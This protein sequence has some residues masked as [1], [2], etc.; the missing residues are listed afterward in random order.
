MVVARVNKQFVEGAL[1]PAVRSVE[2]VIVALLTDATTRSTP[3]GAAEHVWPAASASRTTWL[4]TMLASAVPSV[5]V[6]A[7]AAPVWLIALKDAPVICAAAV[8]QLEQ[9]VVGDPVPVRELV[10]AQF[11]EI[12]SVN[13]KADSPPG[14]TLS[15]KMNETVY[16]VNWLSTISFPLFVLIAVMTTLGYALR[17]YVVE[18]LVVPPPARPETQLWSLVRE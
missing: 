12:I 15:M 6:S 10:P 1:S 8:G 16:F 13:S 18:A 17:V 4:A 2:S 9:V 14:A 7:P 5:I 11:G 3:L